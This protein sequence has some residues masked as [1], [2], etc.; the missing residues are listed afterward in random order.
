MRTRAAQRARIAEQRWVN[1]V[2]VEAGHV[3]ARRRGKNRPPKVNVDAFLMSKREVRIGLWR[4]CRRAR[5]CG[6]LQR[7]VGCPSD[8]SNDRRISDERPLRCVTWAQ[9]RRLAR[10]LSA[11]LPTPSEWQ[12]ASG[13]GRGWRYPWGKQRASCTRANFR[14]HGPGC[15]GGE[16]VTPCQKEKGLSPAGICDLAGNLREWGTPLAGVEIEQPSQ[17]WVYGGGFLDLSIHIRSDQLQSAATESVAPDL[18]I[19]LARSIKVGQT[20]PR[21]R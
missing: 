16:P 21:A 8:E 1:W 14:R 19:R 5:V 10:W 13:G 9:A 3:R 15:G 4:A 2:T 6:A 11:R 20:E 12:L 17:V 18:G 7:G